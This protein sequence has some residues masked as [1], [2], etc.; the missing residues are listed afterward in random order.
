[1]C[2]MNKAGR[3]AIADATTQLEQIKAIA[4]AI[5]EEMENLQSEEQDKFENLP[6]GLQQAESGIA[7][8]RAAEALQEVVDAQYKLTGA[9][10]T[11]ISNLETASE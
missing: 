3:K 7:I 6:E 5:S 4:E 2:E 9:V 8:E 11:M 1:M 10:D